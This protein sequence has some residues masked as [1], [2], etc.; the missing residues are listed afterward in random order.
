ML[1]S[2]R[3]ALGFAM[4]V[5]ALAGLLSQDSWPLSKPPA[6]S[7]SGVWWVASDNKSYR[8][9]DGTDIP[10]TALGRDLYNRRVFD[11]LDPG[12]AG[13]LSDCKPDGIP[14]ILLEPFPLQIIEQDRLIVVVYEHNHTFQ[15]IYFDPAHPP[16]DSADLSYM[17]HSIGHWESNTLVIDSAY[18]NDQTSLD[19]TGVPHSDR[20]H[21]VERFRRVSQRELDVLITIDDAIVFQHAWTTHRV[22][23]LVPNEQISEFVCGLGVKQTRYDN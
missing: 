18:F 3:A 1:F 19:S 2:S 10:F 20:L 14:R 15:I 12:K 9:L 13:D 5:T 21:V 8:P 11:R 16:P 17:G 4:L 22:Y 7:L 6:Q 23:R